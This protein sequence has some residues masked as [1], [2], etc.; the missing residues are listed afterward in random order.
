MPVEVKW[1][2]SF[3]D[4]RAHTGPWLEG[5]HL[6][7]YFLRHRMLCAFDRSAAAERF[8]CGFGRRIRRRWQP[9]GFRSAR[10]RDISFQGYGLVRRNVHDYL[11][12]I[13]Q[14]SPGEFDYWPLGSSKYQ[15]AGIV[16]ARAAKARAV[17]SV[18]SSS[19]PLNSGSCLLANQACACSPH[20]LRIEST[21]DTPVRKWRNWQTHHLEGVAP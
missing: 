3:V 9:D 19:G 13:G 5:A 17:A 1:A 6:P 14:S 20:V 7:P 2:I 18:D 15:Q 8:G 16:G 4:R 11:T 21:P 10:R 12:S